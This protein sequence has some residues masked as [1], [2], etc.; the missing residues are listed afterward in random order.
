MDVV[1]LD[2]VTALRL[3]QPSVGKHPLLLCYVLPSARS[4]QLLQPSA[5][6]LANHDE[7]PSHPLELGEPLFLVGVAGEDLVD[8]AGPSEGRAG[9]VGPDYG[10]E[11][12]DHLRSGCF[13][14][15]DDVQTARPEAVETHRLGVAL[16]HQHVETLAGEVPD[17]IGILED[18]STAET[19]IGEVEERH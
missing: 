1:V 8:D 9:V 13:V 12:T 17:R 16:G 11:L 18:I 4:L 10:L 3:V 6:L 15:G 5:Q 2:Q 7:P 19:L 14:R